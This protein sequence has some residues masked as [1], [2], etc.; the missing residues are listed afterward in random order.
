[1]C[2]KEDGL[3]GLLQQRHADIGQKRERKRGEN[4]EENKG[5]GKDV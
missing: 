5:K 1:M 2:K 3:I 4:K